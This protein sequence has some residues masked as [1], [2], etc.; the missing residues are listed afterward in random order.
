MMLRT[1]PHTVLP[2]SWYAQYSKKVNIMLV[3]CK[4][5][6][7]QGAAYPVKSVW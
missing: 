7:Y 2:K 5:N 6:T 1:S 3:V 4:I